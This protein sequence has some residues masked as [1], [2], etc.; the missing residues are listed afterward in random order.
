MCG[1]NNEG[2]AVTVRLSQITP[3][4]QEIIPRELS[5]TCKSIHN[6]YYTDFKGTVG[7]VNLQECSHIQEYSRL[8][9][10][11][12]TLQMFYSKF[13]Y[14]KRDKIWYKKRQILF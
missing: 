13:N 11:S 9:L 5:M 10:C 1:V 14:F 6:Y 8:M 2:F 7:V 12:A 4:I 3:C